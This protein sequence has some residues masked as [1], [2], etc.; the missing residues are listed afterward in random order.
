VASIWLDLLGCEVR[1]RGNAFR[2]RTIEAGEGK[3]RTLILV[4]GIG[5]QAEAW[6]R[7]VRRLG[8][9]FHTVAFDLVW[10]GFSSKP[11]VPKEMVP[12][13][14]A[15]VIDL[16]DSLGVKRAAIEGSSL[17]GWI[18][19]WLALNHPERIEAIVLNTIAGVKWDESLVPID[20]A[21]GT[22]ALQTRSIAA[23]QNPNPDTLRKRL[24]HV[25]AA[26]ER[27]TDELI[28]LRVAMYS[29]PDTQRALS[30]VFGNSFLGAASP[31]LIS[32]GDLTRVS[33]PALSL[34]TDKNPGAGPK[35]G[36]R[37]AELI[38]NADYVCIADAAHWAP[39]EKPA[40][41]DRAVVAFLNGAGAAR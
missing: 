26:P 25:M 14:G 30:A 19:L 41:H 32:E 29:M 23:I 17:G 15:Q 10:H 2:T 35:V 9:H 7:N 34:W 40:E 38:P 3:P 12:V 27:V 5:S 31:N 4:H 1:M 6:S 16:M 22:V 20:N 11:P 21:A 13:Y 37:L 33:M 39:W 8:E 28:D 18:T 24:E 36:E